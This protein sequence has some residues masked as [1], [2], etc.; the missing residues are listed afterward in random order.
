MN[1]AYF[2]LCMKELAEYRASFQA[3]M[4]EHAAWIADYDTRGNGTMDEEP[5]PTRIHV[6]REFRDKK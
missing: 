1:E 5:T 6:V 2:N 3:I 4:D